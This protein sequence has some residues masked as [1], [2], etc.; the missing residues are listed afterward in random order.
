MEGD[1]EWR[2]TEI[3]FSM[4]ILPEQRPTNTTTEMQHQSSWKFRE[5]GA[6]IVQDDVGRGR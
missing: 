5:N 1:Y 4:H 3:V 2:Y 6:N